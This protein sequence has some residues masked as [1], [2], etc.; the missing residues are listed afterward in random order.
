MWIEVDRRMRTQCLVLAALFS[1]GLFIT[2][3]VVAQEVA[4]PAALAREAAALD[5]GPG[6]PVEKLLRI[7]AL[8]DQIVA[9]YP[10]SDLAVSVILEGDVGGVDVA[11]LEARL[12]RAEAEL[13]NPLAACLTGALV[14]QT[15]PALDLMAAIDSQGRVVGLPSLVDG[16][17]LNAGAR[18]KYLATVAALD[19]CSPVPFSHAGGQV[20]VSV[21]ENGAV[22]I[23]AM[24]TVTLGIVEPA[25]EAPRPS[26]GTAATEA[27]LSL[28]RQAIRDLQARL[29][30]LGHDPNGVDGAIGSGTRG[31]LRSWQEA[32]GLAPTG[33]LN[34][35]QHE[36]LLS[37][38]Q[39][40]LDVWLRSAANA[41]L[42]EPPPAPAVIALTPGRL[43]GTW[44]TTTRCGPGSKLGRVTFQSAMNVAHSGDGTFRGRISTSQGLRGNVVLIL[45]GR[46]LEGTANYGLLIGRTSF[47]GQFAD[48][49]LLVSGSDTNGCSFSSRKR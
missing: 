30:V 28:D 7:R 11:D 43:A 16:G 42:Y 25:N 27:G 37:R 46:T 9:E 36:V 6:T 24:E 23:G 38:S 32:Q 33:F 31:A 2:F 18:T 49:S 14:G 4:G 40:A 12:R 15:G 35:E 19:T 1:L 48:Q 45:R 8:L 44:D 47:R 29:L 22:S 41:Q 3:P 10:S 39:P 13:A 26:N 34:A 21:A 20:R 5:D 17:A